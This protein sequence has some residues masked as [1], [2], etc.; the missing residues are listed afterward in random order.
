M[1]KIYTEDFYHVFTIAG[2][3]ISKG[4]RVLNA[5]F[6][7]T[8]DISDKKKTLEF[9]KTHSAMKLD[10]TESD[11]TMKNTATEAEIFNKNIPEMLITIC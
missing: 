3:I 9:L 7:D 5:V 1:T 11:F 8:A 2:E 10:A 4:K 6:I